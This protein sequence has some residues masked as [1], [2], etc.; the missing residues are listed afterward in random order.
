MAVTLPIY[1]ITGGELIRAFYNSVAG[2]FQ[3]AG[4][5]GLFKTAVALGVLSL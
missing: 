1:T 5:I 2:M 4:I 3:Y